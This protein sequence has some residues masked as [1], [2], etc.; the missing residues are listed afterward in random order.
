MA[1]FGSLRRNTKNTIRRLQRLWRMA[2]PERVLLWSLLYLPI[3]IIAERTL[4]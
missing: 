2:F 3:L 4:L 1:G